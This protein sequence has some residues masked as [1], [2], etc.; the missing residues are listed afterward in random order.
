MRKLLTSFVLVAAVGA[1][2]AAFAATSSGSITAVSPHM[3]KLSDGQTYSFSPKLKVK[4]LK[5]GQKVTV[6]FDIANKKNVATAVT[7]AK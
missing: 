2:S 7:P 6:T 5:I 1:S 4:G 3:L